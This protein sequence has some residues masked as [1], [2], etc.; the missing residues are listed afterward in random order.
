MADL[1]RFDP[2]GLFGAVRVYPLPMKNTPTK[3]TITAAVSIRFR[4][5][6]DYSNLDTVELFL[7]VV[8]DLNLYDKSSQIFFTTEI[9]LT[10]VTTSNL[11]ISIN[12]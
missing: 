5:L 12:M 6:G 10:L 11:K 2:I 3:I 1:T 8:L 7:K 4:A 9:D